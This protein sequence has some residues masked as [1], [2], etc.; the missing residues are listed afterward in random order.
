[1]LPTAAESG[2]ETGLGPPTPKHLWCTS[3][4]TEVPT[5]G[6]GATSCFEHQLEVTVPRRAKTDTAVHRTR[7]FHALD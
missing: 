7:R 2:G 5:A 3:V 6:G 4:G 1:M